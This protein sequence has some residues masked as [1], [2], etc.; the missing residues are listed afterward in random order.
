MLIQSNTTKQW[1]ESSPIC[2]ML[3]GKGLRK[4]SSTLLFCDHS[5]VTFFCKSLQT[6]H[7]CSESFL[8]LFHIWTLTTYCHCCLQGWNILPVNSRTEAPNIHAFDSHDA[9]VKS[10]P[11]GKY[12]QRIQIYKQITAQ[13]VILVDQRGLSSLS[14]NNAILPWPVGIGGRPFEI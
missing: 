1:D 12:H 13:D 8:A 14:L 2:Y 5:R 3:F 9:L 7:L 4:S 6:F 11:Q 10:Q